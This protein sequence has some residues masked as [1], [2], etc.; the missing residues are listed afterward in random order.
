MDQRDHTA[1]EVR[2]GVVSSPQLAVFGIST[3]R[4]CE[5]EEEVKDEEEKEK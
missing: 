5:K 3:L 2:K 1:C 4:K